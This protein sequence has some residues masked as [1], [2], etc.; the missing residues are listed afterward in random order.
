MPQ[1]EIVQAALRSAKTAVQS[2]RTSVL[3]I[4]NG[5]MGG[6]MLRKWHKDP[7]LAVTVVSPRLP[8]EPLDWVRYCQSVDEIEKQKFEVVAITIKPQKV[9]EVL[10]AYGDKLKKD[11]VAISVLAGASLETIAGYFPEGSAVVRAMP[12]LPAKIGQSMTGMIANESTSEKQRELADDLMKSIGEV[13]WV[14]KEDDINRVT[15]ISGSGPAYFFEVARVFIEAAKELG[16]SAE[17]ATKLVLQTMKGSA[18]LA[19]SSEQSVEDLRK[20]VTSPKGTTE[21][22]LKELMKDN[23]LSDLFKETTQAAYNRAQEL[24]QIAA[25]FKKPNDKPHETT[26]VPSAKPSHNSCSALLP[27]KVRQQV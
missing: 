7:S 9:V 14:K 4:G 18:E 15:A 12:N 10:P 27:D 26:S 23:K 16:F 17:D 22:G 6:S 21:A 5:N 11:G 3:V 1:K 2:Q 8:H 13:V 19:M 25:G 24:A 20:A